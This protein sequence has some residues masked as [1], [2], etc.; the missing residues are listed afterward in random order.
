MFSLYHLIPTAI[1]STSGVLPTGCATYAR[2]GG[3]NSGTHQFIV[4]D[5]EWDEF[6]K[7]QRAASVK[8]LTRD[9]IVNGRFHAFAK[10]LCLCYPPNKI[11]FAKVENTFCEVGRKNLKEDYYYL[12]KYRGH[13][14]NFFFIEWSKK[15]RMYILKMLAGSGSDALLID[16]NLYVEVQGGKRL[17]QTSKLANKQELAGEGIPYNCYDFSSD[18]WCQFYDHTND[19]DLIKVRD[20]LY[21]VM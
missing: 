7:M 6:E 14:Q 13:L 12:L 9:A 2:V 10:E 20:T 3:K 1:N 15:N 16:V 21:I 8:S 4:Q 18:Q 17:V 11:T 19:T 5:P